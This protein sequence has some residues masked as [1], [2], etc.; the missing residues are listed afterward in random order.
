[1][2]T[3]E[4]QD[5]VYLLSFGITFCIVF[6]VASHFEF[7]FWETCLFTIGTAMLIALVVDKIL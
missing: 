5:I 1:M 6:P 2:N 3:Q 4:K 7:I